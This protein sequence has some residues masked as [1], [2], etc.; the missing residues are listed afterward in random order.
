[1]R[2]L[3][4]KHHIPVYYTEK[5]AKVAG[6]TAFLDAGASLEEAMIQGRWRSINTPAH[7]RVSTDKYRAFL[8]KK[9]PGIELTTQQ[10]HQA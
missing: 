6:V 1:M 4:K 3:L 7:Y 2:Q 9:V 8:N 5:S 10:D